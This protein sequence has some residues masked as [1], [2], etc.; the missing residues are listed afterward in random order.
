MISENIRIILKSNYERIENLS[1]LNHAAI[2]FTIAFL[3]IM[4]STFS[5]IYGDP[6]KNCEDKI[7][8]YSLI[9]FA[10]II[11][12]SFWRLY[13]NY[14]DLSIIN[15]YKKIDC[16][17]KR[18]YISEIAGISLR[19]SLMKMSFLDRGHT[20][21]DFIT[22]VIVFFIY[23]IFYFKFSKDPIYL[24]I[25]SAIVISSIAGIIIF[26]HEKCHLLNKIIQNK[27]NCIDF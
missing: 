18:L 2:G 7:P 5:T 27:R 17:E 21:I 20:I 4:I 16:C 19:S 1:N 26:K 8:I 24:I 3:G 22:F 15:A 10:S 25:F 23:V 6:T 12:L 14:I 9:I 11:E 13:A